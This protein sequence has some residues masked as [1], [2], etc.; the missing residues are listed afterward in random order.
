MTRAHVLTLCRPNV[1]CAKFHSWISLLAAFATARESESLLADLREAGFGS[2]S[3]Q[4]EMLL[5]IRKKKKFTTWCSVLL[6]IGLRRFMKIF[7][8][9]QC[10]P[11]RSNIWPK[12]FAQNRITCIGPFSLCYLFLSHTNKHT[13][14]HIHTFS[15]KILAFTIA[16]EKMFSAS[17]SFLGYSWETQL[18]SVSL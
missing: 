13:H 16:F 1:K 9:L 8:T 7:G 12:S 4:L 14:A 3:L 11:F 10:I 2:H 18:T 17:R 6:G 15:E 5:A